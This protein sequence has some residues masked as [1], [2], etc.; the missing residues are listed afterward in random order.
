MDWLRVLAKR[1]SG[2]TIFCEL[3]CSYYVV[4]N[5]SYCCELQLFLLLWT[6]TV[7]IAANFNCS[8]CCELQLFLLLRTSTVLIYGELNCSYCCKLQLFLLTANS[9]VFV[10]ANFNCSYCCEL[11][12]FLFMSLHPV[13]RVYITLSTLDSALLCDS[14]I[15]LRLLIL[16]LCL[17][18]ILKRVVR[19]SWYL[20]L[21]K[22]IHYV[23]NCKLS[24][25]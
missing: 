18:N 25:K 11:Q 7:L 17:P 14:E 23:L 5:C 2:S 9:T 6:S 19:F 21:Y 13:S 20:V 24:L 1:Q 4:L 10:A 15:P 12:L 16:W 22:F 8:Y 3:K